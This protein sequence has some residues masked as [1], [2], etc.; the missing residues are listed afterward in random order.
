MIDAVK[1]YKLLAIYLIPF[2]KLD[3]L[4]VKHPTGSKKKRRNRE[5]IHC[6]KLKAFEGESMSI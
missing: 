4:C 1:N 5:I 6:R 2:S 3:F